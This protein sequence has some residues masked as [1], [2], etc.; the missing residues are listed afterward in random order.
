MRRR[1]AQRSGQQAVRHA[2]HV[3][4]LIYLCKKRKM[5]GRPKRTEDVELTER[6]HNWRV[7]SE[8]TRSSVA[9]QL[10]VSPST[11]TRTLKTR[12][13]SA[14]LEER[15]LMLLEEKDRAAD[16]AVEP[17]RFLAEGISGKDLLFLQK[18]VNHILPKVEEVLKSALRRPPLGE[19]S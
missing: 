5:K 3:V 2:S 13:F 19:K 16:E 11:L 18:F 10:G 7:R 4:F 8:L 15:V 1:L 12:S 6:L 14:D 9:E 17:S